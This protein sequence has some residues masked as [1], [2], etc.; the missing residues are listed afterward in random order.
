MVPLVSFSVAIALSLVLTPL[1][2]SLAVRHSIVDVPDGRRFHSSPVPLMGGVAVTTSVL[3]AWAAAH[4]CSRLSFEIAEL[5]LVAGFVL[6]FGLGLYDDRKGMSARGKMLGQVVCAVVLLTGFYAGG[7]IEGR[8]FLLLSAIW[9]VGI[10]NAVNF[11]DNMDGIAAGVGWVAS[12]AFVPLLLSEHQPVA[13]LLAAAL[14]GACLGFLRFNFSPASIFLGDSGSLPIGF[15][16]AALSLAA[17]K[18]ATAG[19]LI[20]PL[21]VLGYPLFDI[22]FVTVVRVRENRKIY[23]G[24]RDHSSHRLASILTS[25]R[26][27]AFT[28]YALCLLLAV[29]AILVEYFDRLAFSVFALAALSALFVVLGIRLSKIKGAVAL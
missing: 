29:I 14:C 7:W 23:H 6:S 2:R 22:A 16:L 1:V 8:L 19:S 11:L 18:Q 25:P 17:M 10:M 26:R 27:T 24:G 12:L 21:I 9:V 13:A 28:I 5:F 4:A 3:A 15:L 20:G